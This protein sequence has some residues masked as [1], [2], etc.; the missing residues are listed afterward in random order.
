MGHGLSTG[1]GGAR[2]F[3]RENPGAA[4]EFHVHIAGR[5]RVL[6]HLR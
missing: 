1:G 3:R 4:A 2:R 6:L 5:A